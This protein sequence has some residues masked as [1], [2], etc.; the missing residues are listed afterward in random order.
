[1]EKTSPLTAFTQTVEPNRVIRPCIVCQTDNAEALFAFT[2]EFLTQVRD[3][4]PQWLNSIGW[5]PATSSTIVRCKSCGAKYTRDVFCNFEE[6]KDELTESEVDEKPKNLHSHKQ[7]PQTEKRL[8]IL[9]NLFR[10][11]HA[12]FKRDISLLDYGAG[13]GTW[14]NTARTLAINRV[15]AYEPYNPYAPHLYA[16][17][18]FPGITASRSW[19]EIATHGPFDTI[20]CNAVF[21]HLINPHENVQ[22]MFDHLTP[23]G[24]LYLHNPFM[25]LSRELP[26]LKKAQ[27]IDKSMAISH[28]HPGHVNYLSPDHFRKLVTSF[29]FKIVPMLANPFPMTLKR[30]V[31]SLIKSTL[32][33]FGFYR[34]KE[35]LLQKP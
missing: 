29:G 6:C 28:Y 18:N 35:F 9:H 24:F 7:F 10:H 34:G 17:Y 2:Y 8:W 1:M 5:T 26:A 13:S 30:Q 4:S 3:Q 27:H 33:S 22:R 23:G 31:K 12:H 20:I 14:S 16:K 25:D 21:E 15:F 32:I 19:D 11:A